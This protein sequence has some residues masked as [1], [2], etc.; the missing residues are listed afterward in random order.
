METM[1]KALPPRAATTENPG[2]LAP[3]E[4]P[5]AN[6]PDLD[7]DLETA[8]RILES[9]LPNPK[10]MD[11]WE[12]MELL[13]PEQFTKH[14]WYLYRTRPKDHLD[15]AGKSAHQCLCR[16][17]SLAPLRKPLPSTSLRWPAEH[18]HWC[19]ANSWVGGFYSRSASRGRLL[20]SIRGS[21]TGT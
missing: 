14:V 3:N 18:K 1:A 19:G 16:N 8:P 17:G 5:V 7:P 12:S 6:E 13:N 2:K 20:H 15:P 4:I 10:A 21:T 9:G 11:V